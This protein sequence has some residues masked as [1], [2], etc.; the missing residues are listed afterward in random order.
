M[1]CLVV[2]ASSVGTLHANVIDDEQTQLSACHSAQ[3]AVAEAHNVASSTNWSYTVL[4]NRGQNL[5]GEVRYQG[6]IYR[7]YY[8]MSGSQKQGRNDLLSKQHFRQ[9]AFLFV[10]LYKE[11]KT[12]RIRY[13]T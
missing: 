9:A 3:V 5:T 1:L 2:L 12:I 11:S 6:I 7:N 13:F 10:L 8:I 4:T